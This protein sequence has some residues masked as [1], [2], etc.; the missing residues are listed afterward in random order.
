MEALRRFSF[1]TNSVSGELYRFEGQVHKMIVDP[2]DKYIYVST[3]M[4]GPIII[5]KIDLLTFEVV[6][7]LDT[8]KAC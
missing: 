3:S 2:Y 5:Y 4:N 8:N 1:R 7:K 6:K